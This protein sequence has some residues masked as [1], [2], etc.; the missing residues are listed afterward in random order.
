MDFRL[1]LALAFSAA[2]LSAV[3]VQPET[4]FISVNATAGSKLFYW[5]TPSAIGGPSAPTAIWLN[6]GPGSSSFIGSFT[7]LG[8]YSIENS[9]LV[10][11]DP[12]HAWSN[13]VNLVVVD[14]PVGVGYSYTRE[15]TGYVDSQ[16]EMA[17]NFLMFLDGFAEK[18]PELSSS[19]LFLTGESYAG[20]VLFEL[21]IIGGNAVFAIFAQMI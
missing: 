14:N 6:G 12:K 13:F 1:L 18:H 19:K 11:R 2:A 21:I 8:P 4:G 15:D 10:R 16:E 5:F 7:G 9:T 20:K 3:S 17:D